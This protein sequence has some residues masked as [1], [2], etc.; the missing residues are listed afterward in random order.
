MNGRP[1][2]IRSIFTDLA[3]WSNPIFIRY[4]R[5]KLRPKPLIAW[6]LVVLSL[7]GFIFSLTYLLP[8]REESMTRV[9]A[10]RLSLIPLFI[11]QCAILMFKGSFSVASGITREGM[12]GVLDYQRLAPL[13]PLQKIVGYLFGLPVLDY[14]LFAVTLPFLIFTVITGKIAVGHLVSLYSVFA[15]SVLLYHMTAYM[16]GMVVTRRFLAGFISQTLMFVLY[17]ILPN[18]K[19]LGYVFFEYLT[20]RPAVYYQ[21]AQIVPDQV[22]PLLGVNHVDFFQLDFSIIGFSLVI[23]LLL[24]WVFA[25][26]VYRKWRQETLHILGKHSS[27]IVYAGIVVALVGSMIPLIETGRIFPSIASQRFFHLE[28]NMVIPPEEAAIIPGIFGFLILA[29]S[30]T[31]IG[32]MTP[33][34]D[35]QMKGWRRV[36]K[37]GRRRIPWGDDASSSLWHGL[38]ITVAGIA[39]WCVFTRFLHTSHW[40]YRWDLG[41]GYWI[42]VALAI[43]AP[44]I[45]FQMIMEL[46]G[47]RGAFLLSLGWLVMLFG[48]IILMAISDYWINAATYLM[49]LSGFALPFFAVEAGMDGSIWQELPSAKSAFF[50]SLILYAFCFPFLC[51]KWW[52][53]HRGLRQ[54]TQ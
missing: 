46:W 22:R 8:L 25:M 16:A 4:C 52:N 14:C 7:T 21:L 1:F 30:M 2:K 20:V 42:W 10:A 43:F 17:F 38:A 47:M 53:H 5:A 37:Y 39:G 36:F 31:M 23:Q 45:F 33:T 19:G 40:Y 44:L 41:D 35:K 6:V 11:I 54:N 13:S 12:E 9:E 50:Y 18:L 15:T 32:Q 24:F 3:F 28:P 34:R 51:S 26:V 48:A 29:L 27:V 49:M